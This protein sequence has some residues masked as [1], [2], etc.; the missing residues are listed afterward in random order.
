VR[1][2]NGR[3]IFVFLCHNRRAAKEH[4]L[5]AYSLRANEEGK[6]RKWLDPQ[7]LMVRL[8]MTLVSDSFCLAFEVYDSLLDL[9]WLALDLRWT[10]FGNENVNLV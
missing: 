7:W 2:F 8:D 3:C 4:S 9:R 1:N 5:D 6:G 10:G